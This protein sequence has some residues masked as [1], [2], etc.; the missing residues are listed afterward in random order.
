[1][2]WA[3]FRSEAWVW[4]LCSVGT[5]WTIPKVEMAWT[6]YWKLIQRLRMRGAITLLLNTPSWYGQ[7]SL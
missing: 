7:G 1:M 5:E 4:G 6:S 3:V 2:L